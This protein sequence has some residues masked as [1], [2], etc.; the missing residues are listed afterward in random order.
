MEILVPEEAIRVSDLVY[1]RLTGTGD[2]NQTE[3]ARL[4]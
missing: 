2:K 1:H 3:P 4:P